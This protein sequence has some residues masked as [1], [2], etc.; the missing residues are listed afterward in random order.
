MASEDLSW[1]SLL[2][3]GLAA[4]FVLVVGLALGWLADHL[5]GTSPI[6]VLI[7]LLIGVIGAAVILSWS[8]SLVRTSGAVLLD[9]ATDERLV[10]MVR[11]RLE[12]EG[13]RVSDLH[14]WRLGP[15]HLGAIAS[16]VADRPQA[17]DVYKS[18]LIGID[19]LAHVTIEV[20]ACPDHVA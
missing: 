19:G 5:L 10:R 17:P 18:R 3:M 9:A 7:G 2:G 1:G 6:F 4:A 15:G 16:I 14:L 20:H 11:E 12:V 13:D 8:A